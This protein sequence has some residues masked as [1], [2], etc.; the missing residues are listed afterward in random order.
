M[1]TTVTINKDYLIFLEENN[2]IFNQ[3]ARISQKIRE[4]NLTLQAMRDIDALC[5]LA[6]SKKKPKTKEV[7][8][9]NLFSQSFLSNEDR[10]KIFN[11]G[12]TTNS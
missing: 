2:N 4:G 5:L 1:E 6:Q 12:G 11:N 10:A 8:K 3:V 9:Q 7:H